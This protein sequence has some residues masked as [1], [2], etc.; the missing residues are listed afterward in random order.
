MVHKRSKDGTRLSPLLNTS[1]L[2]EYYDIG[3]GLASS[4]YIY[5]TYIYISRLESKTAESD[6]VAPKASLVVIE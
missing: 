1:L 3:S 2:K 6:T 4:L 5:S